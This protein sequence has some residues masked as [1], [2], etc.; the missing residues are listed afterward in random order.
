MKSSC[1]GASNSVI[2]ISLTERRKDMQEIWNWILVNGPLLFIAGFAGC[3]L[4]TAHRFRDV[5]RKNSRNITDLEMDIWQIKAY[6]DQISDHDKRLL[7]LETLE[8]ERTR[9][10]Q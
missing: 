5:C 9:P 2:R 1:L 7:V 4:I 6:K 10:M 8:K 3:A